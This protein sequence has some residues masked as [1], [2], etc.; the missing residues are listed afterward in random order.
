M[1]EPARNEREALNRYKG[2]LQRSLGVVTKSIWTAGESPRAKGI[3]FLQTSESPLRLVAEGGSIYF[4]A[5]QAFTIEK[6]RTILGEWKVRTTQYVYAIG[7]GPD[8]EDQI[9]AWHWHPDVREECHLH[10]YHEDAIVGPLSDLHLPTKRVSFEQ[11]LRFLIVDL[12]VRAAPN[13]E[14]VLADGQAR[15]DEFKSWGEAS[16]PK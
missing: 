1:R 8:I 10:V 9:A 5:T 7:G 15:F 12:K 2:V 3:W 11:V 6:S 4:R 13:W 16:P 14:R